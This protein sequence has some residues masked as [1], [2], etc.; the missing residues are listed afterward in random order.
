MRMRSRHAWVSVVEVTA[1]E[2]ICRAA[3]VRVSPATW[4]ASIPSAAKAFVSEDPNVPAAS[5]A[6]VPAMALENCRRDNRGILFSLV[7]GWQ[8]VGCRYHGIS[9][10]A[11]PSE[12]VRK[13]EEFWIA[14]RLRLS[15]T[16]KNDRILLTID[17]R[18]SSGY[19]NIQQISFRKL[20]ISQPKFI[21][22]GASPSLSLQLVH[23]DRSTIFVLKK[24]ANMQHPSGLR[25]DDG[26][27]A[28]AH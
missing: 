25:C 2:R 28:P 21:R 9:R 7:S 26:V 15:T 13:T 1:P 10:A 22:P 6:D 14:R 17:D 20:K 23:V 4:S 5:A 24:G 3:S 27:A 11:F 18:Q 8:S 19:K 16:V 12:I